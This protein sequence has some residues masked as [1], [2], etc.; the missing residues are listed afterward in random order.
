[1]I[2]I[3][4]SD[5]YFAMPGLSNSGMRDLAI[6]PLRFWFLHL[7]PNA[8]L[9]EPTPEMKFGTALHCAVL[10]PQE[11]DKRYAKEFSETDS[12]GCLKTIEDL[13]NFLREAGM[14]PKGTRKADVISQVQSAYPNAPIFDVLVEEHARATA[15]K[16]LLSPED[17][18][19]CFNASV[20]LL[21]EP[22]MAA[23][24]EK[25]QAE[26]S[27]FATDPETGVPLKARMDWVRDDLILDVKTFSQKRNKS[28]DKSISDAIFYEAYYRTAYVYSKVRGWP[29]EW[30]GD[31]VLAFVESDP[32][33]EVR[34]KMLRPK[35]GGQAN[36]YW[37]RAMLEVRGLIQTY[38]ECAKEFGDKPWRY[39]QEVTLLTDE[40]MSQM[41]WS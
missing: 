13:R 16:I 32:P 24:L 28:I 7:N 3:I 12:P 19:R 15:G 37:T 14:T 22:R 18:N 1:M 33:H 40:D 20:S 39:A 21:S 8:P 41:A 9:I 10:E 2:K 4:P 36:V 38:A 23:L 5:E 26:V 31:F 35:V 27:M 34:L 30:A 6:S 11:F 25:G 29:K 17:W